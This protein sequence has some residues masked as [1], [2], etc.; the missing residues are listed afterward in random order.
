[1]PWIGSWLSANSRHSRRTPH[2]A[3]IFLAR[4]ICR[5]AGP[6]EEIGKKRSGSADR[7]APADRQ[8]AVLP[9]ALIACPRTGSGLVPIRFP[10]AHRLHLGTARF[11]IEPA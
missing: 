3:Q 7:Q 2:P 8:F 6:T 1:M 4:A 5:S 9:V 10:P 11:R